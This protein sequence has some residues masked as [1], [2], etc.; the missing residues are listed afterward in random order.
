MIDAA[1]VNAV[2]EIPSKETLIAKFLG[3]IQS[4]L[5]GLAHALQAIID[6]NGEE[7]AP[8]AE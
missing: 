6:K 4:P 5:Y 3:S 7:T 2:A 1:T 8:A